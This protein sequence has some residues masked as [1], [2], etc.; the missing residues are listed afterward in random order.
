M[1]LLGVV[2]FDGIILLFGVLFD[3]T[4]CCRSGLF[5]VGC[6]LTGSLLCLGNLLLLVNSFAF[7]G[8]CAAGFL[9]DPF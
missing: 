9:G 2:L 3:N 7:G 8:R 6:L 4:C 1:L 5:L